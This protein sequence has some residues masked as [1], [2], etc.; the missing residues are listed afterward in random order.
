MIKDNKILFIII[1]LL[2]YTGVVM[3]CYHRYDTSIGT[4]GDL[5]REPIDKIVPL[6]KRSATDNKTVTISLFNNPY[7]LDTSY[8]MVVILGNYL[9]YDGKYKMWL[10]T[11]A[12]NLLNDRMLSI[13]LMIG[14]GGKYYQFGTRKLGRWH[15]TDNLVSICFDKDPQEWYGIFFAFSNKKD[16]DEP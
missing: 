11:E 15:A 1:G 7:N 3:Y 2:I 10:E 16:Y 14:K 13:E 8:R 6:Y 5:M 4:Y 9:I 12:P